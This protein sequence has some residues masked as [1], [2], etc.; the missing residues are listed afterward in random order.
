MGKEWLGGGGAILVP[1]NAE[2]GKGSKSLRQKQCRNREV[3]RTLKEM[4]SLSQQVC[5]QPEGETESQTLVR[6]LLSRNSLDRLISKGFG[7]K[8]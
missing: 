6:L 7:T 3:G 1:G 2:A 5:H 8:N 4:W